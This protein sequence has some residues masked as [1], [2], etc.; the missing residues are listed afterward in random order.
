MY[1]SFTYLFVLA[2]LALIVLP[3]AAQ[4][5]C[6]RCQFAMQGNGYVGYCS[7]AVGWEPGWRGCTNG[8]P[9]THIC[10]WSDILESEES[11]S[12]HCHFYGDGCDPN[13]CCPCYDVNNN[14]TCDDMEDQPCPPSICGSPLVLKLDGGRFKFSGP[15]DPVLFD[16]LGYGTKHLWTWTKAGERVAFLV[17]DLNRNGVIDSGKEMF[18]DYAPHENERHK[19]NGFI[20]LSWFAGSDEFVDASDAIWSR[21]RLWWDKDHDGITDLGELLTLESQGIHVLDTKHVRT[22]REDRHGNEFRYK[23]WLWRYGTREKYFDVY[24]RRVN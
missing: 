11:G 18:G 2:V 3:I 4:G 6:E 20:S 23:S 19:V 15:S 14:G 8:W 10:T 7:P 1:R 22:E 13:T 16:L 12:M 21:L 24:F 5:T 9:S 17:E